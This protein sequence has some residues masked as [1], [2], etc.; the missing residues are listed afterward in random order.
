MSSPLAAD[1]ARDAAWP[2]QPPPRLPPWSSSPASPGCCRRVGRWGAAVFLA[3]AFGAAA[4]DL[5]PD[6]QRAEV[7]AVCHFVRE[8][9]AYP[10][11]RAGDWDAACARLEVQATATVHRDAWVSALESLLDHL[12]DHHVHLNTNTARSPRLFPTGAVV[13]ARLPDATDTARGAHHQVR[14]PRAALDLPVIEDVRRG[15]DAD[16]K[17]MAGPRGPRIGDR[18][19]SIQGVP[20]REAIDAHLPRFVPAPTMPLAQRRGVQRVAA[21]WALQRALAATHDVKAMRLEVIGGD[22]IRRDV[23]WRIDLPARAPAPVSAH[24]RRDGV[25]VV[26]IH[27]ALGDLATIAAHDEAMRRVRGAKA[28]VV[29]LRDTP[30]GGNTDVARGVMGCLVDRL[31]PYQRHDLPSSRRDTGIERVWVEHVAP[32]HATC[33]PP[34]RGPVVTLVGAWTGSMGEGL[35][36]GLE[37][38]RGAP[39]VGRPMAGLRGALGELALPHSAIVVRIPVERLFRVDGTPR[40]DVR[41]RG[42]RDT[43]SPGAQDA[44]LDAAAAFVVQQAGRSN[45]AGR[46]RR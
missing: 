33:G 39:I 23:S 18:I 42:L 16:A 17:R 7:R 4:A 32:R 20:A 8:Q 1:D 27:D 2:P 25:G 9:D 45:R 11:M 6:Q 37:A 36:I 15:T 21:Q 31:R 14:V 43:A 10:D 12:H 34:F 13:R 22:G 41:P 40:E 46:S 38:A 24:V 29:D 26:T 35:A 28:L 44:Q 5:T 19:V 30:S 3:A